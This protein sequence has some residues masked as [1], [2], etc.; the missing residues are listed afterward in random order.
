[1]A[2]VNTIS[3]SIRTVTQRC[4]AKDRDNLTVNIVRNI[5]ELELGLEQGTLKNGDWKER[6]KEGV[7]AEVVRKLSTFNGA[8]YVR[9]RSLCSSAYAFLRPRTFAEACQLHAHITGER[10]VAMII[11]IKAN[12]PTSNV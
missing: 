11:R 6:S 5:V 2:D 4:Y 3:E 8:D 12:N 9:Q 7:W 1:M 10:W